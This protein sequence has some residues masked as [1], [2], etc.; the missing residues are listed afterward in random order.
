MSRLDKALVTRGLAPTRSRAQALIADGLVAVNGAPGKAST[1]V[2]ESDVITIAE[3]ANPYVSR[4]ALKLAHALDLFALT[5]SGIAADIGASTGGFTEVLLERGAAAV[6]AVEVG[7]GQ[8][9]QALAADPRVH[10]HEGVNARHMPEGLLPPLDWIVS[11]VSFIS[12]EKALPPTLALAKPGA[13]LVA[14]IKPQF[15]VGPEHVGKG[16][17]VKDDAAR[18]AARLRIADWLRKLGWEILGEAESPITGSDGNIEYL[19][20]ARKG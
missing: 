18:E 20:A 16:G 11:D 7:H 3:G 12:L 4:A 9:V 5:P 19:I 6:H 15:E 2:A 14:L 1:K 8:M 10:L 17:I 13:H